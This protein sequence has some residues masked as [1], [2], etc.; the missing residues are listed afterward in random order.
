MTCR[1]VDGEGGEHLG[2]HAL[3][4]VAEHSL[5][6]SELLQLVLPDWRW[7]HYAYSPPPRLQGE[8][9]TGLDWWGSQVSRAN[10]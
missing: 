5:Y 3:L 10:T 6:G 2:P 1:V 9:I 8:T 4:T 7:T